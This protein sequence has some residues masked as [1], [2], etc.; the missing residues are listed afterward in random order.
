MRLL[1]FPISISTF[2]GP[3]FYM[4]GWALPL[5]DGLGHPARNRPAGP[6]LNVEAPQYK[7]STT[8]GVGLRKRQA[9]KIFRHVRSAESSWESAVGFVGRNSAFCRTHPQGGLKD[10][11]AAPASL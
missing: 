8:V 10:A 7:L 1:V 9:K 11:G 5:H 3:H 2:Q 4:A 6:A